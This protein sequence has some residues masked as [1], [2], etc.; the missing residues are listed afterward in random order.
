MPPVSIHVYRAPSN[1]VPIDMYGIHCLYMNINVCD[2][3]IASLP[4]LCM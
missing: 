3:N 4:H 1:E 2:K